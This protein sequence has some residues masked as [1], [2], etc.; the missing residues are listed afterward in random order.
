MR[1]IE[2]SEVDSKDGMR[3]LSSIVRRRSDAVQYNI[4]QT[5]QTIRLLL[6][7][8]RAPHTNLTACG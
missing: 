8:A 7:G 5:S 4:A 1:R 2:A 3:E 6:A